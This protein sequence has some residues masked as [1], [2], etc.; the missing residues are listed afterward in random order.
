MRYALAFLLLVG[1]LALLAVLNL[2]VGS[3]RQADGAIVWRLRAPRMLAAAILGGGL[4]LS[5]FLLQTFFADRKSTRL[6][7]SH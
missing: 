2:R 6:N 3:V 4:S 5:G 1:L 7:S